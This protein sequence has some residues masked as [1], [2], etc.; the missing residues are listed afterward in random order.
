VEA[1]PL[2][3]RPLH[4]LAAVDLFY[5]GIGIG[6]S[7]ERS[8]FVARPQETVYGGLVIGDGA[9]SVRRLV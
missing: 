7:Y 4:L 8:G 1:T 6:S 5:D 9:E 3:D 2:A